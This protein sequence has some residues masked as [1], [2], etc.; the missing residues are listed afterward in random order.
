M[1]KFQDRIRVVFLIAVLTMTAGSLLA[2]DSFTPNTSPSMHVQ[3]TAGE[4]TVDGDLDDAGWRG[5][6]VATNFCENAPGD[7]IKPPVDTHGMI[8]YDDDYLYVA[9]VAYDNPEDIRASFCERDRVYGDDNIGFLFDTY[10]D[11][12]WAYTLNVNPHGIQGDALWSNGFGEDD[13][14]DLIWES[15]GKVT[16]SGYQVELAIPFASLR[17]PDKAVQTW[18]VEFW[19]HHRRDA[20]HNISWCAYDRDEPCW[21]CQWGEVTGIENVKPGRGIEIIPALTAFQSGS[22]VEPETEPHHFDNLDPDGDMSL[23]GKYALSSSSTVEFTV[24]P[25]FSQVEAD[26]NQIDINTITALSFPE[27][28]PFFQEGSDL[29]RSLYDVVYTRS[30]NDP[31]FAAK[32]TA[33]LGRTNLAYLGAYDEVSPLITPF[34]DFS[35]QQ[36]DIGKSMSNI[37]R[38]RQSFGE[39]SRIG[40]LATDRRYDA[41]GSGSALSLDGYFRLSKTLNLSWQAIASHTEEL[42]DTLL[43]SPDD[44]LTTNLNNL[45][46]DG[47]HTAGFDGESFSG[48]AY[49]AELGYGASDFYASAAIQ[50]TSPTFRL[51]NGDQST[52]SHRA[53]D[54]RSS[55]T[56]RFDDGLIERFQP[57]ISVARKWNDAGRVKKESVSL[58]VSLNTRWNRTNY[59]PRIEIQSRYYAGKVYDNLWTIHQCMSS[60]PS[61][62]ISF[63]A[64]INYGNSIVWGDQVTGRES[65]W[66]LWFDLQP[67]DRLFIANNLDWDHIRDLVTNV[68]LEREFQVRSSINYQFSPELSLRC[69]VQYSEDRQTLDVDPLLTYRINPFTMFYIGTTYDYKRR[70]NLNHEGTAYAADGDPEYSH[71]RLKG[72]QFFMKLQYLFQI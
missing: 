15:A 19:R 47:I 34:E 28:R 9:V 54:A 38:L 2:Q 66:W 41:G 53:F 12:S 14:Y 61:K 64:G 36:N 56:F 35:N 22:L 17:F 18:K 57:D 24:N 40:L 55:Y 69:V 49:F 23:S 44:T 25:D 65:R 52:N 16:D 21:A 4:I 60:T 50:E 27:K 26:A 10:G 58:S 71:N 62:Y 70:D 63:G 51:D 72:R 30:I 8:T 42:D 33:R 45:L 68:R 48:H 3:R 11:A 31:I 6:A 1:T 37:V 32:A 46:F 67:M 39:N 20:H 13:R 59:H 29:F 43:T 7:Q 5:A